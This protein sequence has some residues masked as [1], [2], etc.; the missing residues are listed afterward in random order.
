MAWYILWGVAGF[1]VAVAAVIGVYILLQGNERL[2]MRF[3]ERTPLACADIDE[4]QA[5]LFL[6]I[7]IE[8]EGRQDG[9]VMDAFGRLLLP[10]E[11]Y[12]QAKIV[13]KLDKE[14]ALRTDDYLPAFFIEPGKKTTLRM[15]FLITTD[16]DI[17]S[18]LR[19]LPDVTVD[20]YCHISGRT[21]PR[22]Y[23]TALMIPLEEFRA[24]AWA[25]GDA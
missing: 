4:H 22:I 15:T 20:I 1:T 12:D 25:K 21:K 24:C 19:Q 9:I 7:P 11:Q 17:R 18:A 23:K 16:G 8:N 6:S 13:L 3:S 5:T 10:K 2:V 14:D